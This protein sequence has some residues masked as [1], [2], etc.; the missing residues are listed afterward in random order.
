M[1]GLI[2]GLYAAGQSPD[3]IQS[4]V[5]GLDW[6]AIL[7]SQPPFRRLFLPPKKIAS[8]SPTFSN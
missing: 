2:G 5:G 7:R 1:G 8:L 3:S 4:L 6:P